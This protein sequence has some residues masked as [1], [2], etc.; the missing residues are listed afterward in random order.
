[1]R[2][3]SREQFVE[4]E[5]L[6]KVFLRDAVKHAPDFATQFRAE[7]A[8]NTIE[9]P[10]PTQATWRERM[11]A[12]PA[13]FNDRTISI[14]HGLALAGE[15]VEQMEQP[16]QSWVRLMDHLHTEVGLA[17]TARRV[18]VCGC[19]SS[20]WSHW[21]ATAIRA[22]E[23]K[24][25]LDAERRGLLSDR[26]RLLVSA[27]ITAVETVNGVEVAKAL[28]TGKNKDAAIERA[29]KT[30]LDQ[31]EPTPPHLAFRAKPAK[32]PAKAGVSA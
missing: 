22:G 11:L 18:N 3:V 25:I 21:N 15:W 31:I 9:K 1:M 24:A 6:Y 17:V 8:L 14:G 30:L 2:L 28:L 19:S 10:D 13:R 23:L 4:I 26:H 27:K 29:I 5:A 7:A 32:T 20:V 12:D 16:L